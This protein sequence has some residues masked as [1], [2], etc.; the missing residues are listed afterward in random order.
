MQ[1]SK[2]DCLLGTTD[3][4]AYIGND[5]KIWIVSA[6]LA[7]RL[8]R[9]MRYRRY[10]TWRT[11]SVNVMADAVPCVNLSI[12]WRHIRTELGREKLRVELLHPI[13]S[14]DEPLLYGMKK[15]L[16]IEK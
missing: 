13:Q 10:G 5:L 6:I 15:V 4:I 14:D 3:E 12:D 8:A 1:I 2:N 11:M 9:L 16:I 7:V